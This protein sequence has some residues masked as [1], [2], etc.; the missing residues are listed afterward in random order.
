[1]STAQLAILGLLMEKPMHGYEIKQRLRASPG[2][3][4]MINYGS[5]YP[6]LQR[7]EKEECV[8]GKEESAVPIRKVYEITAKGKEK[9]MDL[10]KART[11]REV[12]VRDE[13]TLHLFFL[14]HLPEADAKELLES[15]LRGNEKLLAELLEKDELLKRMLPRYRY[16]ALQRGTMHI[17]TEL[18]WLRKTLGGAK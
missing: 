5:I 15:K 2:V 6:T 16:A 3:F 18:E 17:K 13:F 14:D 4:W 8:V 1:M 9:F 11:K 7:L 10:L 12:H